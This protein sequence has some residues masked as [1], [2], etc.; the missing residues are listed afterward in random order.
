MLSSIVSGDKQD[1]RI[2]PVEP[3]EIVVQTDDD[4][5]VEQ[6]AQL[7]R[8]MYERIARGNALAEIEATAYRK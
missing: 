2:A 5:D 4:N 6:V 8:Q 3:A 7:R 1:L